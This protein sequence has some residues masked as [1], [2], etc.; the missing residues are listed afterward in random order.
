MTTDKTKAAFD[1]LDMGNY[2]V[3]KLPKMQKSKFEIWMAR[4]GG[5]LAI[6]AFVWICWFCHIGF[7]DNL[8]TGLLAS[9]AQK[10]L[11]ALG[12]AGFIRANYAMLAIFVASLILWMTEAIPNY[13]T[14]LVLILLTVLFNVTSQKE[15]LAQL[16][17]PVM[18]LN[19][20]SFVLASMLVKTQFAKR[21]AL[22]FVI[23]FGKSAKGVLW[24]FLVINLVLSAFISA[25]TVKATIMLPIFM[26]ICA[27]YG[28]SGGHRNN[29]GR[30]LVIQNLFQVNIG[31]NAFYTGSGAHLL[32]ISLI[33]GFVGSCDFGYKEWLVA[34]G[35]MS[36]I[37]LVVGL[38]LGM[39]VFFPM[40]KEEQ[41]PQ[42]EGGI[43]RL[44]GELAAMGKM[45]V[46]E[47]KAVVIFLIVLFLWVTKGTFH[48]IDETIVAL[49]GAV[50]AL[51]PGIG[52][53]KWNDVDI[54]WHLM[55]F[56]AGAYVLGSGH[57]PDDVFRTGIPVQDH[58]DDGVR[59]HRP[60]RGEAFQLPAHEPRPSGGDA[61]RALLR[62]PL[63]QQARRA[64]VQ[65]EPIQPDR[66]L[67]VRHHDDDLLLAAHPGL[68]R[69]R[70]QVAAHH[71]GTV[72]VF[73]ITHCHFELVEKSNYIW[74]M[75]IDWE[76]IIRLL[77]GGLMGGVIGLE[78][79]FRAKEAGLRTHFI[80]ALGSALFMM[81][82]QYAFSGRFDAARVAAQV[83][84]GIGFIGAGVI[85]FQKNVVRGVTTAAGLWVAAAIGLACGAGMYVV[86]GA[87]TLMTAVCLETMHLVH[88]Y[89]AEKMVD[90]TLS[91]DGE[92]DPLAVLEMV[93]KSK[94]NVESY[95]FSGG[96]IHL[97]LRMR[98][99]DSLE[100]LSNFVNKME[101]I[102]IE[103]LY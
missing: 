2:K 103:D 30:N 39:Y 26:V 25:T 95:S 99:K 55:L 3:E 34:V 65:H 54:P 46:E 82:S 28:A 86:A 4:L 45:S 57:L 78:R 63:Q 74:T 83:V 24:S 53:V 19:I 66:C 101:G 33:A 16:G 41:V 73:R 49:I 43:D 22:A 7:I 85:I 15:A 29:F 31:A 72:L 100:T 62:A 51:I 92:T 27:I 102:K 90:V 91:T 21:L 94:L 71:A 93:K 35:P 20:L 37:I 13:L 67:Q 10:R 76:M 68:R 52:V 47:W 14:S 69:D 44:K 38:I 70:A 56:S 48:E 50:L 9:T 88:R 77:L 75:V 97:S 89:V 84:S 12:L 17:H 42:I 36:V 98:A 79:E 18:W 6:A 81:I 87:A 80:V 5:P 1:P 59:P 58:P 40:K 96:K 64:A 60:G 11:D 8:D 32:A 61:H 23:K